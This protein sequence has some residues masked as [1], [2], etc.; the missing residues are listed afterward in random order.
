MALFSHRLTTGDGFH[1][2]GKRVGGLH[3]VPEHIGKIKGLEA[4]ELRRQKQ[5]LMG[6]GG[7]L[8]GRPIAGKSP[9]EMAAEVSLV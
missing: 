3:S 7:K 4:A 1:S 8:G 6:R 9:R 2:D 5:A